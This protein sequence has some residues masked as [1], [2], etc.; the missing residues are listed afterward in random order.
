MPW[1]LGF[2]GTTTLLWQLCLHQTVSVATAAAAAAVGGGG[3]GGGGA[4]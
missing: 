3:G 2:K 1:S 4:L